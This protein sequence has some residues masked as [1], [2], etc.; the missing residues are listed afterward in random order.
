MTRCNKMG[1]V[2]CYHMEENTA[3]PMKMGSSWRFRNKPSCSE[4]KRVV[5]KKG[6]M[7]LEDES[8]FPNRPEWV[9]HQRE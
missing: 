7:H 5:L 1:G 2:K 8:C 6:G 9:T 3:A 4:M